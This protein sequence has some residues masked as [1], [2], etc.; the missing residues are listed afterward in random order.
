MGNQR[1]RW[2]YPSS[3]P[4]I[5]WAAVPM[6]WLRF[7][8]NWLAVIIMLILAAAGAAWLARNGDPY[9]RV[10]GDESGAIALD[11]GVTGAPETYLIDKQGRIAY[12]QVGIITQE[13]WRDTLKPRIAKLE[14]ER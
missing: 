4:S 10:G 1:S 7:P 12:K 6:T 5:G 8:G 9:A 11:L 13:I 2:V 3:L 14:A